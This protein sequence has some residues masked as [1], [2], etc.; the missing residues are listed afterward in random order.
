LAKS[1]LS[2]EDIGAY[3]ML[4]YIAYTLS[5]WWVSGLV[6]AL[7]SV[8]PRLE[9]AAQRKLV[10]QSWL[11]FIGISGGL[12]LFVRLFEPQVLQLLSG[13]PHVQYFRLF[14][15]FMVLHFPAY[16]LENL[17][18]LQDRLREIIWYGI[19]TFGAQLVAVLLPVYMGY[20]FYWSI[21]GLT[22]SAA[23]R[24]IWL[25]WHICRE[26]HFEWD[27]QML[28]N[29]LRIAAPLIL[30]A[31]LGGFN[32]VFDNW[33]VNWHYAGDEAQ[34][35]I[36]RYGA[37][38]LPLTLALINA[39]GAAMIPQVATDLPV[40]LTLVKAQ[41][42]RLFHL[43][44]PLSILLMLSGR[45]LF[46]L[47]FNESFLPSVHIF[48]IYLLILISRMLFARPILTGLQ[49]NMGVLVI[50]II[51]LIINTLVSLFLVRHY[52]MLG[53][54]IG[55]LVAYT[56]EKA[57]LCAYLYIRLGVAVQT[58]T[59]LRWF[60]FYSIA[61]IGAYIITTVSF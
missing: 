37:Q 21:A 24:H 15:V 19:F 39:F 14:T 43:L 36:F 46:P 56:I 26:G 40:A 10:A 54:A 1:R 5:F 8:Y 31:V 16:L 27:G 59:D 53:I 61:L 45:Q 41:S 7:L 29:W 25:L 42:L 28:L 20:D 17:L 2:L 9:R 12:L 51:E 32:T 13:Q 30:Y 49:A 60:A 4:L 3:E 58:Y 44:F 55:T 33:L 18:L 50:S 34:F 47:V 6:Q 52:G 57:M 35:A 48:N 23:L 11:L 22:L 38:E